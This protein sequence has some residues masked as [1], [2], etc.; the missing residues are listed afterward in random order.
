MT[1][2]FIPLQVPPLSPFAFR[3]CQYGSERLSVAGA[4]E[5]PFHGSDLVSRTKGGL[6]PLQLS[7]PLLFGPMASR[8]HSFLTLHSH[9]CQGPKNKIHREHDEKNSEKYFWDK[10]RSASQLRAPCLKFW[11]LKPFSSSVV[12]WVLGPWIDFDLQYKF[13]RSIHTSLL[14]KREE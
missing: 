1:Q 3:Q 14:G 8:F 12:R 6:R 13:Q 9:W 4:V 10:K 7:F 5:G 2:T 11:V